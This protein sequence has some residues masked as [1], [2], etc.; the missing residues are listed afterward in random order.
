MKITILLLLMSA[1]GAIGLRAQAT[2]LQ[3]IEQTVNHY[4]EGGTEGDWE[5][6]QKAFHPEAT[7][8]FVRDAY[9]SVNALEFF[10]EGVKTR[11][12]QERQTRVVAISVTGNAASAQLEI[13]YP[14]HMFTDYMSL[15]KI[16]GEWKIVSKIF[17]RQALD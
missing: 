9:T 8:T 5:R 13:I 11:G 15:L 7:M 16:D 6:F 12:K 14:K 1:C 10:E 4:L 17:H 2:D 3:L